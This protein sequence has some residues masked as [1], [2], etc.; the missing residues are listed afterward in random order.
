MYITHKN[1]AVL[2]GVMLKKKM[3]KTV[4]TKI[5]TSTNIYAQSGTVLMNL[6]NGLKVR[7]LVYRGKD[8]KEILRMVHPLPVPHS[9]IMTFLDNLTSPD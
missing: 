1:A 9:R 7:G 6:L 5:D 3:K 8:K 4:F 2:P